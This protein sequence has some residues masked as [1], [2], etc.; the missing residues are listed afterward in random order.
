MQA[1]VQADF[2]EYRGRVWECMGSCSGG[3]LVYL[4]LTGRGNYPAVPPLS[5]DH[6]LPPVGQLGSRLWPTTSA[7]G[8][9]WLQARTGC[10]ECVER[11][12]GY[13]GWEGVGVKVVKSAAANWCPCNARHSMV[14]GILLVH[15]QTKGTH[16]CMIGCASQSLDWPRNPD[17][18]ALRYR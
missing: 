9:R 16:N 5:T 11:G 17:P 1:D 15:T 18:R 2:S 12:V 6:C 7:T 13:G 8:S 3:D 14:H 4:Y 10:C